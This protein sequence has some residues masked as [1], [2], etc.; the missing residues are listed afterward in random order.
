M[1]RG[2]SGV[3]TGWSSLSLS[4]G[5][6]CRRRFHGPLLPSI[7]VASSPSWRCPGGT[8]W[9][10]LPKRQVDKSLLGGGIRTTTIWVLRRRDCKVGQVSFNV[11]HAPPVNRSPSAG[12]MGLA[13]GGS[14]CSSSTSMAWGRLSAGGGLEDCSG[15]L[16]EGVSPVSGAIAISDSVASPAPWSDEL[17]SWEAASPDLP[18]PRLDWWWE[19]ATLRLS[20]SFL[21]RSIS[22]L[23]LFLVE[24]SDSTQ[25]VSMR[26][27]S[28]P[29]IWVRCP[30]RSASELSSWRRFSSRT[31][32]TT[33]AKVQK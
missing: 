19:I 32:P 9:G 31:Q 18:H 3:S 27:S 29:R 30:W 23:S 7:M 2:P 1:K 12:E 6:F 33:S 28:F 24:A 4:S 22:L 5:W 21:L 25:R 16:T 14:A 11:S 26:S 20:T 17:S 8:C 10:C 13:G 15:A